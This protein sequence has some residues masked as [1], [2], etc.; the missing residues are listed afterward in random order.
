MAVFAV[1]VFILKV[2]NSVAF[3]YSMN[4]FTLMLITVQ[5]GTF[6]RSHNRNNLF[7][8]GAF[9]FMLLGDFFLN[10]TPYGKLHIASFAISLIILTIG[11]YRTLPVH[12]SLNS[13]AILSVVAALL[14]GIIVVPVLPHPL[15]IHFFIYISLLT[16]LLWRVYPYM[17]NKEIAPLHGKF[18]FW[19][20]TLFYITDIL[21]GIRIIYNPEWINVLIYALYPSSLVLL[22]FA[23][24]FRCEHDSSQ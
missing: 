11:Y 16:L 2:T 4:L 18:L 8:I 21:V 14:Y 10:F 22:A 17:H 20:A 9:S 5:T 7:P 15:S 24:T 6:R 1:T 23:P 12:A 3:G 13:L 19:G